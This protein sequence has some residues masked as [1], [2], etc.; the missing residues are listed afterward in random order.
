MGKTEPAWTSIKST[1]AEA[2][3]VNTE[4]PFINKQTKKTN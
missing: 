3:F 4:S 2:K 1:A